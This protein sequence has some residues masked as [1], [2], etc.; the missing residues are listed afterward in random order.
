[1]ACKPWIGAVIPPTK[2]PTVN[3]TIPD[4]SYKLEYVFGYRTYECNNNLYAIE[5]S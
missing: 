5:T 3:G 4:I 1:M 2:L